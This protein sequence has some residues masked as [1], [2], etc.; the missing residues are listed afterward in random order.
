MRSDRKIALMFQDP[1][2]RLA[3]ILDR[4]DTFPRELLRERLELFRDAVQEMIVL[5][6]ALDPPSPIE[7]LKGAWEY[8]IEGEDEE[9]SNETELI[10]WTTTNFILIRLWAGQRK[11]D[12]NAGTLDNGGS[13]EGS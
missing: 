12:P 11:V 5:R 1:Y 7:R 3:S 4:A 10:S 6:E 9:P 13:N 8:R 2:H